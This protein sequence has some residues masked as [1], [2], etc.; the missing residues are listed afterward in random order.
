VTW[1]PAPVGR[2]LCQPIAALCPRYHADELVDLELFR[3][4]HH[5]D[6]PQ[7]GI[8]LDPMYPAQ[9]RQLTPHVRRGLLTLWAAKTAHF[10]MHPSA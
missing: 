1:R 2:I 8:D 5:R 6:D 9:S 7:H 10:D 3:I 4:T